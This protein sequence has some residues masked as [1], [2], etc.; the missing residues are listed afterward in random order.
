MRLA[1]NIGKAVGGTC[2][3]SGNDCTKGV[4]RIVQFRL[5]YDEKK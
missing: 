3:G 4:N 2:D 1:N 5:F